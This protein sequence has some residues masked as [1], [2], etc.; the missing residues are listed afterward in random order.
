MDD[1]PIDP[2]VMNI[3]DEFIMEFPNGIVIKKLNNS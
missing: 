1:E 3:T 2:Y